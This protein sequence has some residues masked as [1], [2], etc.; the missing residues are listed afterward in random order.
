MAWGRDILHGVARYVRENGP[1]TI[2]FEHRSLQDPAPPWL[3]HWDGD[4]IITTLLPQFGELILGTGIP[5]VDL[6]DQAPC[7]GLPT[8]QS[9]QGAIGVLAA[10]HLLERG[11]A[12]F[13]FIGYSQFDDGRACG[14][15][16]GSRPRCGPPAT[17]ARGTARLN[18]S[19]GATS[20]PRGRAR[21]RPCP[22]G[23]P[24]SPSHWG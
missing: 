21:S 19:H 17:R 7:S 3:R 8:V 23:S 4:G 10:E 14:G 1:W 16:S 2:F 18:S 11:F 5:T 20:R 24:N 9:D 13:A 15:R 22:G 6:D 12:R